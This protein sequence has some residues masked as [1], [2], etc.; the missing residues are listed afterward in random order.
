MEKK[1][2]EQFFKNVD[3]LISKG[4]YNE[5]LKQTEEM[6]KNYSGDKEIM[7]EIY[8]KKSQIYYSKEGV[9]TNSAIENLIKSLE[10]RNELEQYDLL[11]LE[12]MNLAY[13]QDEAGDP[14]KAIQSIDEALSVSEKIGDKMLILSLKNAKADILSEK[15]E[16]SDQALEV[17]SSVEKEAEKEKDWDNYFEAL[18]GR[19]KILRDRG[20]IEEAINEAEKNLQKS[21]KILSEC[22][23]KKEKSEMI[24]VV[25]YLYDVAIDLYMEGMDFNRAN[26]IANRLKALK[27]E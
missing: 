17:Y 14:E 1:T 27:S 20:N 16:M 6:E 3:K 4:M 5:A 13:M 9:R 8:E 12:M 7:A 26:E 21:E 2:D 24:N 10:L 18:V 23:T 11:A 25:S 15:N 22:K 19:I